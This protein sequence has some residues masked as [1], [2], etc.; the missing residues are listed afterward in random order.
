MHAC[1]FLYVLQAPTKLAR[2]DQ[3]QAPTIFLENNEQKEAQWESPNEKEAQR[4]SPTMK[5]RLNRKPNSSR[6][7]PNNENKAQKRARAFLKEAQ[8]P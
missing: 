7:K 4:E 3:A 2:G 6:E 1:S 5:K 8:A